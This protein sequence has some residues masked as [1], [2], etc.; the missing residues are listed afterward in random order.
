MAES[1]PGKFVGGHADT[2]SGRGGFLTRPVLGL[3]CIPAI[4]HVGVAAGACLWEK[5]EGLHRGTQKQLTVQKSSGSPGLAE[6]RRLIKHFVKVES[7]SPKGGTANSRGGY[8]L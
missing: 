4:W 5:W 1:S 8:Y 2:G 6:K 7:R 3:R